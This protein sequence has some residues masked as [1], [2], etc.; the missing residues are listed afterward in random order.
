MKMTSLSHVD[1]YDIDEELVVYCEQE[2]SVRET[3]SRNRP[4]A[5]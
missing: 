5:I 3:Y 2:E 4:V 1:L